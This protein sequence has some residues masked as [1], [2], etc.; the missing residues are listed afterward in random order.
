MSYALSSGVTGLQA[1]QKMLDVTGNNVANVNTTAFK[2][3]R[4]GFAELMSH[5]LEQAS[6]PTA[7]I[8]GTNPKQVGHGVE[9][10][11][12]TPDVGQGSIVET[13]SPLDMA[14]EGNGY[15]VAHNGD[16]YVY[17]RNGTFGVDEDGGLVDPATGYHVQ[18]LGV[19][20]ESDGFQIPGDSNIRIP[21]DATLPA[22]VTSE[23]T[24]TGNLSAD[25]VVTP[26]A[27]VLLSSTTYTSGGVTA[28]TATEIDQLD[29]FSGG[30]EADGQLAPGETGTLSIAGFH[31][32]GTAFSSG[33]TFAVTE[34]TTI[35]DLI[36]H[37]NGSVLSDATASFVEGRIHLTDQEAGYSQSDIQLSY[38]GAGSFVTPA[39]FEVAATGGGEFKDVN[40]AIY[41]SQGGKH[42]LSAAL[43][44][45]DAVNTWDMV[46]TSVTGNVHAIGLADRRVNGLTFDPQSGAFAGLLGTEPADFAIT[47]AH[48]TAQPQT[49]SLDLGT[50]GMFDGL[51]QFAGNSTAV[52]REQDGYAAGT[53]SSVSVSS[54]G[55]LNGYFSN[56]IKKDMAALQVALFNNPAALQSAGNGYFIDSANSGGPVVTQAASTGAGVIRGGAL[57]KSNADVA[58]EFVNLIQAQNGYQ[59]NARTIRVATDIFRELT[60][61]IR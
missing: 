47:F 24:L 5:T 53:L 59:A 15:F 39:Y 18:R 44:R 17:T 60:N 56:G 23:I 20:G 51:T 4:V 28:S 6:E 10:A 11:S 30:L 19:L 61:L 34:S 41:N 1:H 3:S 21:Q 8:G 54:D 57:E 31:K 52:A 26:R 2:A 45:T 43:V 58:T 12:I 27:Q 36:D 14:I 37:L 29:Q 48:N 13:G 16:R 46:L 22:N 7:T 50:V 49:I 42:V 38:S 33:L 55:I 32:D 9:V 40:I 25:A 35:Q